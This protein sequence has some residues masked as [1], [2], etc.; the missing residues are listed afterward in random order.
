MQVHRQKKKIQ[1]YSHMNVQKKKSASQIEYTHV[2][3][4][5]SVLTILINETFTTTIC[6]GFILGPNCIFSFTQLH[7]LFEL[8]F[9]YKCDTF[10]C[11][12]VNKSFPSKFTQYSFF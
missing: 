11:L 10:E 9:T 7:N 12:S 2:K 5:Q 3:S 6:L 8:T 4:I 1:F